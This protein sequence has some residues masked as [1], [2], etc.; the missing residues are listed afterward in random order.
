MTVEEA[1]VGDSGRVQESIQGRH[2]ITPDELI[3]LD[4]QV[5]VFTADTKPL[6]LSLTDPL[7][8]EQALSYDPPVREKHKISEFVK[9]RGQVEDEPPAPK[10]EPKKPEP[11]P[12]PEKQIVE[13]ELDD[14]PEEQ[15][16]PESVKPIVSTGS[17]A[18][19]DRGS[20]PEKPKE[21]DDDRRP[22]PKR[23]GGAPDYDP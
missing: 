9:T 20:R 23:D 11:K 7:A 6:K 12:E 1:T 19:P 22:I 16:K 17:D 2:L 8:Y 10:E 15:P 21:E 4:K 5:I 14:A 3:S 18:K 13:V